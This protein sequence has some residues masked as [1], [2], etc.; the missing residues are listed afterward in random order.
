PEV[1]AGPDRSLCADIEYIQVN[2]VVE[3]TVGGGVWTS[4][5]T[6]N[7][8]NANMLSTRYYP[9]SADRSSPDPLVL[10]LSTADAGVCAEVYDELTIEFTPVPTVEAGPDMTVCADTSGI[11]LNPV[12]I[13]NALGVQWSSSGS[14][15]MFYPNAQTA[16][17]RFVPSPSQIASGSVVLTIT[18]TGNGSCQPAS[19][20]LTL[21]IIGV[22]TV[23]AGTDR[24]ICSSV[25]DVQLNGSVNV[26]EG[27]NSVLWTSSGSGSFDP[28]A[29]SLTPRYIP[30]AADRG[31]GLVRL[32]LTTTGTD[33]CRAVSD[34]MTI[35]I[36]PEPLAVAGNDLTLCASETTISLN[37]S[38]TNATGGSWT[39]TGSGGFTPNRHQ[40]AT[41]Y[42]ITGA[43]RT[44]GTVT[45]TLTT[46]GHSSVC[47]PSSSAFTVN[48]DPVPAV[49]PGPPQEV[50]ANGSAELNGSV[51]NATRGVW[52][53]SGSGYFTPNNFALDAEYVPSEGDVTAGNVT[54]TLT[55][56]N[57]GV[58]PD[59]S[60]TLAL[61]VHP[62]PTVDAGHDVAIC[63]GED[64]DIALSGVVNNAEGG[65]WTTSGNGFFNPDET[66]VRA[67]YLHSEDDVEDGSVILTLTTTGT[68]PC[69]PVSDNITITYVPRPLV[70]AGPDITVCE[71]TAFVEL[72]GTVENA[73]SGFWESF[74]TGDFNP[75]EFGTSVVYEPSAQDEADGEVMILFFAGDAGVC[76]SASDTMFVRFSNEP[77]IGAGPDQ[78]VC[79]SEFPIRLAGTGASGQWID[80]LGTFTPNRQSLTASYTPDASEI[81]AGEVILTIEST[82][83]GACT[84]STDQV[85]FVILPGPEVDAGDDVL[86]CTTENE[87]SL[88]G[89][90]SFGGGIWTRS[91]SGTIVS[92]N[93]PGGASYI[94]S[95][96]DKTAGQVTLTL[97]SLESTCQPVRDQM[98]IRF[99]RVPTLT[100]GGPQSH[101]IDVNSYQLSASVTPT[102]T[103]TAWSSS[104]GHAGFS[105]PAILN[106]TYAPSAADRSNNG[107]TLTIS[108]P[109]DGICPAVSRN[110]PVTITPAPTVSTAADQV[111]CADTSR[112]ILGG[113]VG[114]PATG[115]RWT[116]NG[117]GDFS[118]TANA[119]NTAYI[120]SAADRDLSNLTFTLTT[121]GNGTCNSRSAV[122]DVQ[123][124]QPPLVY[125]GPDTTVCGDILEVVLTGTATNEAGVVWE[126][127]GIG[128]TW[129]SGNTSATATY[130]PS[131]QDKANGGVI[132]TMTTT[133]NN[134]C[135]SRSDYMAMTIT[136]V[137]TAVVTAGHDQTICYSQPSIQLRGIV[138][139]A[140]GG[141]WS[142]TGD[143]TFS[144]IDTDLNAVYIV[145][146]NDR[147][148]GSAT[149]RLT[150]I[151][152][153][154]CEEVVS[155]D[156]TL[157][158][159]P[160]PTVDAGDNQPWCAANTTGIQ[161]DGE[162]TNA[163]GGR[164]ATSG[165]GIFAPNENT[166]NAVY[167]PSAQDISAGSV[168]LT[169]TTV[170]SGPCG[171][172]S[173]YMNVTIY[174]QP[175]VNAGPDMTICPGGTATITGTASA[176]ATV[177]WSTSGTGSIVTPNPANP[178][179]VQYTPSAAD[180]ALGN[181]TLTLTGVGANGCG[182]RQDH[183]RLSFYPAPVVNAGS[184]RYV[185]EDLPSLSLNA[186]AQNIMPGSVVWSSTGSGHFT[187][188][189]LVASY[190][191]SQA[192]RTGGVPIT[193]RVTVTGTNS[194]TTASD[195]LVV[196][197]RPKPSVDAGDAI[198]CRYQNGAQLSGQV[199][200]ALG[201]VWSL[202]TGNYSQNVND[203]NGIYYPSMAEVS[204]G[205]ASLRLTSTG[206][207]IC[208][209]ATDVLNIL[210]L[211][212]PV[213]NAGP[214]QM[215][216]G[217][218]VIL[219]AQAVG[220]VSYRWNDANSGA[221]VS[222]LQV[223]DLTN[224]PPTSDQRFSLTVTDSRNCSSSDE[225]NVR[226]MT[227]PT[228]VVDPYHCLDNST[229]IETT[230][231]DG[232][233]VAGIYQWFRDSS[234]VENEN[235]PVIIPD[236]PGSYALIYSFGHCSAFGLTRIYAPPVVTTTDKIVCRETSV[237]LS[238]SP[239]NYTSY[240]WSN[241]GSVIGSG[242]T[243]NGIPAPQDSSLY[244]VN[245]THQ[246]HEGTAPTIVC[247]AE[248]V[249]K[250]VA[251]DPPQL[252]ISDTSMCAGNQ[253][254]LDARPENYTYAY[255]RYN[256]S[257]NDVALP[258]TGH[259]ITV[260][261]PGGTY[262]VYVGI[263]EC[264]NADTA[265][266][267]YHGYPL[268][269]LPEGL[270]FCKPQ[271]GMIEID[272]GGEGQNLSYFWEPTGDTTRVFQATEGGTYVVTVSNEHNCSSQAQ[273]SVRDICPPN[274][275][276]PNAFTPNRDGMNEF[277]NIYG[278]Y[279]K[280]FEIT[281]FSRWGEII[282]YSN[283]RNNLWDGTYRGEPMPLGVYPYI[284]TYE[285][286][287]E[288]KGPYKLEG[289]ITVIR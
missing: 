272:A 98:V 219:V 13:T 208:S 144:P 288:Y 50:C 217:D 139:I 205:I 147:A 262:I 285:G 89:S 133:G 146:D 93:S 256:W 123:I 280:N 119:V 270:R 59:V 127:S 135:R 195:E 233:P 48:I 64:N 265:V 91:G 181:I 255:T 281:I 221:I 154:Y 241:E 39:T 257:R 258:D 187:S 206:N 204:A 157:T 27:N 134:P 266:V 23:N 268:V 10:R 52:T 73:E 136:P 82:N 197:F 97:T 12:N 4:S 106:P 171:A 109:S 253:V 11:Q 185:C 21:T 76:G 96:A 44:A 160:L 54:L 33:L 251:I 51:T 261:D 152:N 153:G 229:I 150:T 16:A 231:Q 121:T 57:D 9:S 145:G 120:P 114:S 162:V 245:V 212:P 230:L 40:L 58:C 69:E 103:A 128:G 271:Q 100:T 74:G 53:S 115:G 132:L 14:G 110:V 122:M 273:V 80:G 287:E 166:L 163:L 278:K 41:S 216:C 184:D 90:V 167:H 289:S 138:T 276:V 259:T 25:A 35:T 118:T 79:T 45:F 129:P 84:P 116:T 199:T 247:T 126:S 161:L 275:H 188:N 238:V 29:T 193:L 141:R 81:S 283:D 155:D 254:V 117:T 242:A 28:D 88:D 70:N 191:P 235:K 124:N 72:N 284:I 112:I 137:P 169:L 203:L 282:F 30:S 267:S 246:N 24:T 151:E 190:V 46:T 211:P 174:R 236:R 62:V 31:A 177:G 19:D 227:R 99:R 226:V 228:V 248:G 198:I 224:T 192:D 260:A 67:T 47:P 173:D 6:G 223:L 215:V 131:A 68:G 252:D 201:G 86:V 232:S 113:T 277:F 168:T 244:Y 263:G 7:F 34:Q 175:I 1:N 164:W 189:N 149:I 165:T 101:C 274:L 182:Q 26:S 218:P 125:A 92:P 8:Q 105:D 140:G 66:D 42:S 108:V 61:T 22:P 49:N 85:R 18:T 172:V 143:G 264:S 159:T 78:T 107:V 36:S 60:G 210:V 183:M 43:D 32:T 65:I 234:P 83:N 209:P 196:S 186:S 178:L 286:E 180:V 240:T 94:P 158:I 176:N 71:G 38:V 2:G 130:R 17:S 213:A 179:V 250:I 77:E 15:G 111:V 87:I 55:T 156:F 102:G 200:N 249:S 37:G 56:E 5:G 63:V 142:T 3:N 225:V 75:S 20:Q 239:S 269:S 148:T 237:S 279:F 202:G 104:S 170:G 243:I 222:N 220:N 95:A 194:C 207:G 214:D